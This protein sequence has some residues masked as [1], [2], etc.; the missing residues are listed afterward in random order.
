MVPACLYVRDD[1]LV[2]GNKIHVCR[3][4]FQCVR[5]TSVNSLAFN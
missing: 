2:G 5:F 3:N 4:R 1:F